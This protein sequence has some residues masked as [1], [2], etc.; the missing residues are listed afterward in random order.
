MQEILDE[1]SDLNSLIIINRSASNTLS[2]HDFKQN[3][4][5]L[6]DALTKQYSFIPHRIIDTD[7]AAIFY[8]S[9]STGKPKG[10]VLSHRNMVAGAESVAEYLLALTMVLVNYLLHF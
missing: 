6:S 2:D 3:I 5:Y 10:V 8:T 4:T 7:M 1:C 9:G